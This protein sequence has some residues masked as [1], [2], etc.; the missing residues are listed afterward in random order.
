MRQLFST[1]QNTLVTVVI[2]AVLLKAGW[3]FVDWAVLKAVWSGPSQA[4]R[5]AEGACWAYIHEKH[6]FILFGTYP[7]EL[8]WRPALA[9]LILIGLWVFSGFRRSWKP[10]LAL[11]WMN[12]PLPERSSTMP[13]CW[14]PSACTRHGMRRFDRS[15]T[16]ATQPP[17][18]HLR[19]TR[20]AT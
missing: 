13:L 17:P 11:V 15:S 8:H 19:V 20:G 6:R 2:A 10:S 3:A 9:T 16:R 7:F 5:A 1:W 4:C 14:R 12:R 18:S